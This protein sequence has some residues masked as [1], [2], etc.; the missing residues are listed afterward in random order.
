MSQGCSSAHWQSGKRAKKTQLQNTCSHLI[1][2]SGHHFES[3]IIKHGN[4]IIA[5]FPSHLWEAIYSAKCS[6]LSS[7]LLPCL[8]AWCQPLLVV[9]PCSS[10]Q[11]FLSLPVKSVTLQWCQQGTSNISIIKPHLWRKGGIFYYLTWLNNTCSRL[12]PSI[13]KSSAWKHRRGKERNAFDKGK[14]SVE[15]KPNRS[16]WLLWDVTNTFSILQRG[17]GG[18]MEDM[19]EL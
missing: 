2:S 17:R 15:K 10:L 8:L 19:L 5:T 1:A 12:Q 14:Q 9:S 13:Y 4:K 3:V 7:S 18:E 16:K 11:R 6:F